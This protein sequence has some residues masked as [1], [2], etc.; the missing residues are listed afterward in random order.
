VATIGETPTLDPM[1][2]TADLVGTIRQHFFEPLY[3]FDREWKVTRLLAAAL[4][5]VSADATQYTIH[6]RR[7]V[8]FDDGA[9]MTA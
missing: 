5:E 3:M 4:P 2:A 8:T 7:D 6:L 1:I 9:P